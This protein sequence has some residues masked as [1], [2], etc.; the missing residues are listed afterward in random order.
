MVIVGIVAVR[1]VLAV[2]AFFGPRLSA[3]PDMTLS[4]PCALAHAR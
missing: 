4:A 3:V 2:L 1:V